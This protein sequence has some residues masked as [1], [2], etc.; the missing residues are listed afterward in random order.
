MHPTNRAD[1]G[2]A[3]DIGGN[4]VGVRALTSLRWTPRWVRRRSGPGAVVLLYH[5]V[6]ELRSDP[7][8]LAVTPHHFAEHLDVVRRQ[9]QPIPLPHLIEAV[10]RGDVPRG[11]IAVTF[12]DG[13]ADNLHHAKP[14]LEQYEVPATVFVT[15]GALG[16]QR[17]FWW[18]ELDRLLLQ[19]GVL[20]ESVELRIRGRKHRWD[21]GEAARYDDATADR[22]RRWRGWQKNATARHRLY[23]SLWALL[24]QLP[25]VERQTALD[26]VRAWAGAGS[27][28]RPTH[29]SVSP[30]E[31]LTL[32]EGGVVDIGAHTVTHPR[33]SAIP[34]AAQ[35]E[36][37]RLSKASLEDMLGRPVTTFAYPHGARSDYTSDTVA[38]ARA[39]GFVCACSAFRGAVRRNSD[40]FQLPRFV[41]QDWNGEEFARR[42]AG[43]WQD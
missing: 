8:G 40:L 19:P 34:V 35:G 39:S 11:A 14:A 9:G 15:T 12:D 10:R 28:G 32:A 13:Y 30:Q 23:R 33:L 31:L 29:R 4:A 36:E 16:Q 6:A 2:A 42:L 1:V 26:H 27:T 22:Y 5:R 20:P 3:D 37:L 41:V 43:W 38:L 25:E 17:E 7:W 18:D 21:L 24:R